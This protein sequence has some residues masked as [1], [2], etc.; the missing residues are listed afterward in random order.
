ML[1]FEKF[2][3]GRTVAVRPHGMPEGVEAHKLSPVVVQGHK[4]GPDLYPLFPV[5]EEDGG[6]GLSR[7]SVEG[8]AVKVHL[9]GEAPLL[10]AQGRAPEAGAAV[11]VNEGQLVLVIGDEVGDLR[12]PAQQMQGVVGGDPAA[13]GGGRGAQPVAPLVFGNFGLV[14]NEGLHGCL[15]QDALPICVSITPCT[16]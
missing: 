9:R 7:R 12:I 11:A 2:C 15:L 14:I 3:E 10:K 6:R 16:V 4:V 8:P 1:P 5:E 13:A